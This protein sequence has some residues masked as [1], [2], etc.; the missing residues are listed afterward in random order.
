M[1]VCPICRALPVQVRE[2][3]D[4]VAQFICGYAQVTWLFGQPATLSASRYQRALLIVSDFAIH[5]RREPAW[6]LALYQRRHD[7]AA[8]RPPARPARHQEPF[9]HAR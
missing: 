2:M 8:L 6:Q 5:D 4:A 1:I 9:Q 7:R 3:P